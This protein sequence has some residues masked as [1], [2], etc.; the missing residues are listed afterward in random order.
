MRHKYR[1]RIIREETYDIVFTADTYPTVS[2]WINKI[3]K[4]IKYKQIRIINNK[5][6]KTRI[7][8]GNIIE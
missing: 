1:V 2:R 5:T 7:I 8:Q 6:K 3:T 4:D